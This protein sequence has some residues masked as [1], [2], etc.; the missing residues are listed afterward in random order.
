MSNRGEGLD[1]EKEL[2]DSGIKKVHLD[3]DVK[4]GKLMMLDNH[5]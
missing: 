2:L 5:G 4:L 1:D 3:G